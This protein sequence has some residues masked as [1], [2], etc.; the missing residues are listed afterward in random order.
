MYPCPYDVQDR[1]DHNSAI[2]FKNKI[3]AYEE[4][5]LTGIKNEGTVR[6]SERSLMMGL[7]EL[8]IQPT[9]VDTWVFPTP[10]KINFRALELFFTTIVKAY[11]G[12]TKDFKRWANNHIKFIPHQI[13]HASLGVF[14]S[15]FNNS[16]FLCLDGGGDFGDNRNYVFGEYDNNNFKI[17]HEARGTN[18]IGAFHAFLTDAI[19]LASNESGKVSG[20]AGY[21]KIQKNLVNKYSSLLEVTKKGI[22]FK[23]ERYGV[24]K[25][26]LEKVKPREYNRGKFINT[27]PSDNNISRSSYDYLPQ[28]IAASGEF[29]F[30]EKILSLLRIIKEDTSHK[31][32]VLSGGIFQNVTLNKFIQESK[33]FKNYYFNMASGD[34]GL[35]LGSALYVQSKI[36]KINRRRLLSPFIGPSYKEEE[37]KLLLDQTRIK[38]KFSHRIEKDVAKLI[39]SGNC[40]GWFQGRA[41]YGPRSL[42]ARSILADP[43]NINSKSRI[44]QL[45]KKRDW[46]MPYAPSILSEHIKDY[47]EQPIDSPYM[48][49]AL[50]IKKNKRNLIP[51]A[52]HIDGSSRVHVINKKDNLK[53]WNLI[54]EFRKISGVPVILNTSF[55][56]HGISTISDPKQAIE[57]LL[58]G[59]M[60]YLAIGNYLISFDENRIAKKT[61]I[62]EESE[63]FCLK[64]DCIHRLKDVLATKN[65]RHIKNYLLRLEE[66]LSIKINIDDKNFLVGSKKIYRDNLIEYLVK[67]LK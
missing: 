25:L 46:F 12:K 35:S 29:V 8:N 17:L 1:H 33:I 41:E 40:I 64:R 30:R 34:S 31:N 59:C 61:F 38:Y 6:F 48:Q 62:T 43:R 53:Y 23:R 14:G 67:R 37:I 13:S 21:G 66:V 54:N 16:A 55:N 24:T 28:D 56:R 26:N 39:S 18:N 65:K 22:F 52:I 42:G 45:L 32:I 20:L 58:D 47:L 10:A 5:K 49:V 15:K 11:S 27:Y 9:K 57:H 51:A 36:K 4:E 50:N 19:G 2:I 7:K 60:D 3:Y 63:I 44:N